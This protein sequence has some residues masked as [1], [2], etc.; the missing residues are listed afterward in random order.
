MTQMERKVFSILKD[1][2]ATTG[3]ISGETGWGI[4][5]T[6]AYMAHLHRTGKIR[7]DVWPSGNRNVRRIWST[8]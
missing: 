7:R 2:P 5:R 1:G 3:E 6:S 4:H 8:P